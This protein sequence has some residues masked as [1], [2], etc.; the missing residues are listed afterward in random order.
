MFFVHS[1]DVLI[2][3]DRNWGPEYSHEAGQKTAIPPG[4]KGSLQQAGSRHPHDRCRFLPCNRPDPLVRA[5]PRKVG[6]HCDVTPMRT[7]PKRNT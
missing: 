7:R 2:R 5:N 3:F 4:C 1:D 6:L